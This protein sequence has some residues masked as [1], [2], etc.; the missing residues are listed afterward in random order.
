MFQGMETIFRVGYAILQINHEEL[1]S[2]DMEGMLR[3]RKP[4]KLT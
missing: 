3:V 4:V 1:L 2:Q